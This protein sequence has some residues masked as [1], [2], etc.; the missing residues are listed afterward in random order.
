ML[1]VEGGDE[2]LRH[3]RLKRDRSGAVPEELLRAKVQVRADIAFAREA[4]A[5]IVADYDTLLER[6]ANI[7]AVEARNRSLL[8]SLEFSRRHLGPAARAALPYLG[9]F[10]GGVFERFFLAFEKLKHNLS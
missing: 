4:P 2:L 9:W 10:E 8:A 1:R 5:Q 7:D 6:F 3:A